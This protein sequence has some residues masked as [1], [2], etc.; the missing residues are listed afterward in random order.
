MTTYADIMQTLDNMRSR[1]DAAPIAIERA[2]LRAH[3]I[4]RATG[5]L[6]DM[7]GRFEEGGIYLQFG[8]VA[9]G[10]YLR[11]EFDG[12]GEAGAVRKRDG[13]LTVEEIVDPKARGMIVVG[14]ELY[15]AICREAYALIPGRKDDDLPEVSSVVEVAGAL[16]ERD[17]DRDPWGLWVLPGDDTTPEDDPTGRLGQAVG[18]I[19][20]IRERAS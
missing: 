15:A 8:G 9:S 20:R 5:E 18:F 12:N 3:L 10:D 11:Y 1:G 7:I 14:K 4:H 13:K 16:V 2:R 17:D 6:P 19:E